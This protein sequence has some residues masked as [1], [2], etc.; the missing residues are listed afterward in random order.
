MR[1][2]PGSLK[3]ITKD[4]ETRSKVELNKTGAY[5]YS[6][7]PSTQ[8]TC[9]A[10]KKMGD[11]AVY[12]LD[13]KAINRPWNKQP[14]KLQDMW[15]AWILDGFQFS[16]HNS[17][18]EKCIYDNILVPRYGWPA[19]P[20]RQRRCTA[21]KAAACAIPRNLEGAGEA[22]R[23]RIQKDKR[24]YNAMRKTCKPTK[25]W[26]AWTK[27]QAEVASGKR[28]TEKRRIKALEPE[29]KVFC[30][31]EDD[32]ETWETLYTYCKIDVRAEE[33]LDL[34][35]PDLSP[36]EQQIWFLNQTQNWRG[37][38][39]DI[40]TVKKIVGIMAEESKV[41]LK[42]LDKATMGMITQAGARAS[43]LEFLEIEGVELPNLRAKTIDDKLKDFDLSEEAREVLEIRK[44]MSMVSTKKY[45]SFLDRANDDGRVRDILLYHGASTGRE[46]GAGINPNNFPKGLIRLEENRPY[47]AVENVVE[48]GA[49]ML[50]FLYGDSLSILFSAILRNM[51]VPTDGCELFVADFSKIEVA[52]L[53][54]LADNL[55][56][57]KIL[58]SGLDPYKYM[59]AA[60]TGRT[61]AEIADKG[62][63]RQLGKA[64]V[65]GCGYGMGHIKFRATAYDLYRLKLTEEQSRLAVISYR[66]ANE[67]VPI[68][69]KAYEKAAI[70]A[71]EFG[72][73]H[74]ASK[75]KF[76]IEDRFLKIE[77]PSGRRLSYLDPAIT[78]RETDYG[79][80]KT[81]EFWGL[82]KS[83]KKMQLERTWGG[84][85]TE[86][87]CQATARDLMM[88]ALGRLEKRGYRAL[89]S[90]YDEGL[91]ER[92]KGEGTL[93]EFIE[94]L[95]ER[96]SWATDCPIEANGWIGPRYRK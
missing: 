1:P 76:Y 48:C 4:F 55:P 81:L 17:F 5:K 20:P 59:A 42:N 21:A 23:L 89:L 57:L 22:M 84:T 67:A 51:I 78:M 73:T 77:L 8:P 29:P 71:V 96:P 11:P 87:I 61:Y 86:N 64:Q 18:F 44:A 47:S 40:E 16:A 90:V 69:W 92:K 46:S 91:C 50:R 10:F 24:G 93:K 30:E 14:E 74:H 63:D 75:C 88:P 68:L 62:D 34:A 28:I 37:L 2:D 56:G 13:F 49:D 65:L 82:D 70:D 79:P 52:I 38:R 41:K 3:R 60:N 6:L 36:S 25:E 53:W 39:L 43:I 7:D 66:E 85:I 94:I 27:L 19:I 35:L 12:F 80:R 45:Q 58:R 9:F 72:G 83:K 31:P 95:C 26:K 54:W 33:A 32:P 15:T